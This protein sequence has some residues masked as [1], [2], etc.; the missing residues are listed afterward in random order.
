MNDGMKLVR[1][2]GELKVEGVYVQMRRLLQ[3]EK[4]PGLLDPEVRRKVAELVVWGNPVQRYERDQIQARV[5][6]LLERIAR[7]SY[8]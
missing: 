8:E 4:L 6:K 7:R 3:A 2:D 5:E 1:I